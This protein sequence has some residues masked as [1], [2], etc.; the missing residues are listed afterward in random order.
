MEKPLKKTILLI[1]FGLALAVAIPV[2]IRFIPH[3]TRTH[4][5]TLTAKKYGYSP[6]R[7][8]VNK[9]DTIVLKPTSLDVTHGF[10]L[11][12]YPVDLIIKQKGVNFLKYTW[13]DEKGALQNDWDKVSEVK[14]VAEKSGKFTFRC[15]QTCGGLHP[16]MTGE[17]IVGPNTTYHLFVSLSIWLTLSLLLLFRVRSPSLFAGF[18]KRNL[19]DRFSW[20]RRLVKHRSFQ[21]LV[22]FPNFVIF[23]LFILSALWG[24]PV[25]NRKLDIRMF[26]GIFQ[27]VL[28]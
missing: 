19:L 7:I 10:L 9:G 14:F 8:V 12:G 13:E 27:D 25:G 28:C 24:S 22:I 6:S 5:I 18:Q 4:H 2:A 26:L 17:L 21:F 1:L 15:T 23:Y 11:D 20:L 3:E 16:F